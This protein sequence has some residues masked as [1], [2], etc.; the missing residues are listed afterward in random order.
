MDGGTFIASR[1][2][3]LELGLRDNDFL[4]GVEATGTRRSG[5]LAVFELNMP[6]LDDLR[7]NS[8]PPGVSRSG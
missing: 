7:F 8:V 2:I 5:G 3:E 4:G 6:I 1:S